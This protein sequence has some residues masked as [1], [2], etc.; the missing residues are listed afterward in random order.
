MKN[1]DLKQQQPNPLYIIVKQLYPR[2]QEHQRYNAGHYVMIEFDAF[3]GHR[4]D[5]ISV[6]QFFTKGDW[7]WSPWH[8]TPHV[9]RQSPRLII[10]KT[11]I[12]LDQ[13]GKIQRGLLPFRNIDNPQSFM[14]L[15]SDS[16][17]HQQ[18]VM[19]AVRP[20]ISK[21]LSVHQSEIRKTHQAFE[22]A[23]K[24]LESVRSSEKLGERMVMVLQRCISR[25]EQYKALLF[26]GAE[27][28]ATYIQSLKTNQQALKA[29]LRAAEQKAKEVRAPLDD[30][31]AKLNT[32]KRFR[33]A[34][35]TKRYKKALNKKL[36]AIKD[37]KPLE[38]F[39]KSILRASPQIKQWISDQTIR[40]LR[41]LSS[42]VGKENIPHF[43][44]F[45]KMLP[46]PTTMAST[47]ES[48][49]RKHKRPP[50]RNKR[51]AKKKEEGKTGVRHMR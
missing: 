36:L 8:V 26:S 27:G 12:Y 6:D 45:L 2:L 37:P 28:L 9:E 43:L 13:Q 25:A 20:I 35:A 15:G 16:V 44:A 38:G 50:R 51:H 17:R 10:Y 46:K 30:L 4:L 31:L 18:Q 29:A 22:Q 32:P 42:K 1:N 3:D 41:T 11:H 23:K 14:S 19:T 33:G 49:E 48:L 40:A 24:D 21:I 39:F 47:S 34:T 7:R 5:H